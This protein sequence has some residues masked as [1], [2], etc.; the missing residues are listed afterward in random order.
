MGGPGPPRPR[1]RSRTC[2]PGTPSPVPGCAPC[3]GTGRPP[4]RRSGSAGTSRG[5]PPRPSGARPP[6]AQCAGHVLGP[7]IRGDRVTGAADHQDGIRA[8]GVHLRGDPLAVERPAAPCVGR[9]P[10]AR[11]RSGSR[12]HGPRSARRAVRRATGP[13]SSTLFPQPTGMVRPAPRGSNKR[14]VQAVHPLTGG[15]QP[16]RGCAVSATSLC[17]SWPRVSRAS[18][19]ASLTRCRRRVARNTLRLPYNAASTAS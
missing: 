2:R 5:P 14:S 17:H 4:S 12:G 8:L 13:V 18:R 1:T 6:V 16:S 15:A 3:G 10:R 9:P 7:G 19:R 11:P